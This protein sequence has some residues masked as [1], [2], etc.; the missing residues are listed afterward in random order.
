MG[1]R[2]DPASAGSH[3]QILAGLADLLESVGYG[4]MEIESGGN[5]RPRLFEGHRPDLVADRL[6]VRARIIGEVKTGT[7]L[8]TAH[9]HKQFR[10]FSRVMLPTI[11][12]TYA[13]FILAVPLA[14]VSDAW[15]ALRS[16]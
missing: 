9:S 3:R 8:E 7:D 5:R 16:S 15:A 6:N 13:G 4:V 11:P 14:A 1:M 10:A 2:V 12:V